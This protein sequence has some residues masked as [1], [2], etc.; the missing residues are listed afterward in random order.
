MKD[1]D[2][3]KLQVF[4]LA[5]AIIVIWAYA[6]GSGSPRNREA[7]ESGI[8]RHQDAYYSAQTIIERHL[9]SPRSAKWPRHTEVKIWDMANGWV[10]INGHVDAD[11]AFGASLRARFM[12]TLSKTA[13][14]WR[15]ETLMLNGETLIE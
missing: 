12:V 10:A 14:G 6:F 8:P 9:A 2:K 13:G 7:S 5:I 3:K 1:A 15:A 11:N 4:A